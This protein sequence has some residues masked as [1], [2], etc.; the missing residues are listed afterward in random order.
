MIMVKSRCLKRQIQ[1]LVLTT[2][3]QH[4]KITTVSGNSG[5]IIN[6]SRWYVK[7]DCVVRVSAGKRG[8]GVVE[9]QMNHLLSLLYP[10]PS[11]SNYE[12]SLCLPPCLQNFILRS[13]CSCDTDTDYSHSFKFLSNSLL[14]YCQVFG[15]KKADKALVDNIPPFI[16]DKIQNLNHVMTF[17][18][19]QK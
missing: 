11:S 13:I 6:F 2:K 19:L 16:Y 8:K 14:F 18:S 17:R 5:C 7:L 9:P 1:I 12:N 10:S 4:C 3:R 15:S